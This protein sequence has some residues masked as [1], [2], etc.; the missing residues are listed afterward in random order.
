M[1][2][3]SA[4]RPSL[5]AAVSRT[6]AEAPSRAALVTGASGGIGRAIAGR[7]AAAGRDL[8]LVARSADT[9]ARDAANYAAA[10]GV[11]ALALPADLT[12][13]GAPAELA[14]E[15]ARRGVQID[16]LVNNAGFATF[17]RFAE[18]PLDVELDEIALNVSA[19]TALTK[20][21]LPGM[22]E[23][24]SGRILNVASTA[25]FLPGPYM[26]VYYATKAYVLS[27]GLALAHE[28]RESGVTVTTLCPGATASGFQARARM[29]NALLVKALPMPSADE[30]AAF[31]LR[32]MERGDRIAVHGA[33]NQWLPLVVRLLPRTL[34]AALAARVQQPSCRSPGFRVR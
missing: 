29:E 30:V 23:R 14:A 15:L 34:A 32:A 9:L 27:F 25:A 28:L 7:L 11:R 5:S 2:G 22:L 19:L 31:G 4:R 24:R 21:L 17:G 33:A 10:H 13:S 16:V 26:A 6:L 1:R 3:R 8:V 20:L 12:R 18:L